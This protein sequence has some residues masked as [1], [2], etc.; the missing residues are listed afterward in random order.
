MTA[1]WLLLYLAGLFHLLALSG[2]GPTSGPALLPLL[3]VVALLAGPS[4][5]RKHPALFQGL[6]LRL[7]GLAGLAACLFLARRLSLV[8]WDSRELLPCALAAIGGL[9][10]LW[11]VL[12]SAE[13]AP[14]SAA[15]WL[16]IGGWLGTGFLDPALPLVGAGLTGAL[17]AFGAF[18][19][20]AL[21]R[22]LPSPLT[23]APLGFLL[24]GLALPKPWWDFGQQPEWAVAGAALG[25]GAALASLGPLR[26]RLDRLPAPALLAGLGL[27]AILYAPSLVGLWGLVLGLLTA[28][29]WARAGAPFRLASLGGALLAGLALSFALHGNLW[30]PGLRRLLW[31][32]NG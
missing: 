25:L 12:G 29:L 31:L 19:S 2:Y 11:A 8:G 30:I 32:G 9:G 21:S 7:A 24:L 27:L 6:P 23:R 20:P 18:P 5:R 16:W 4:L 10:S 22:P 28:Q 13:E 3:P 1:T 14:P 17:A 15:H 26:S